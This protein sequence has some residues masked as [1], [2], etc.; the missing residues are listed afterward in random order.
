MPYYDIYDENDNLISSDVWINDGY[1]G[2]SSTGPV[3]KGFWKTVLLNSM[4]IISAILFIILPLL[5][6]FLTVPSCDGIWNALLQDSTMVVLWIFSIIN[7]IIQINRKVF[8]HR[9]YHSQK[10]K[11]ILR[12][13]LC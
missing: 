11:Y 9:L 13:F 1:Y 5:F 7:I 12:M 6:I 10:E 3:E 8:V 4:L 2:S